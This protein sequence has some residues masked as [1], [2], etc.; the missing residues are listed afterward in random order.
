V[1]DVSQ[2]EETMVSGEMAKMLMRRGFGVIPKC[3]LN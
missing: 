2:D 3:M 1:D